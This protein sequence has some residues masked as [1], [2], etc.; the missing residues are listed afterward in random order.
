[1][2]DGGA[3]SRNCKTRHGKYGCAIRIG[4]CGGRTSDGMH[5][6]VS[7]RPTT[8]Y[9]TNNFFTKIVRILADYFE[10]R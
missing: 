1:M 2:G 5:A 9:Q 7:I 10:R 3:D 4:P 8:T 6:M